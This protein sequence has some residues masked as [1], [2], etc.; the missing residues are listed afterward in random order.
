MRIRNAI[1]MWI[2]WWSILWNTSQAFTWVSLS[3]IMQRNWNEWKLFNQPND[4]IIVKGWNS[5]PFGLNWYWWRLNAKKYDYINNFWLEPL[6]GFQRG[7]K[8]FHVDSWRANPVNP[9]AYH[10]HSYS[11][12]QEG[13]QTGYY[14]TRSS[15]EASKWKYNL[16][17]SK[18]KK[19]GD[20]VPTYYEGTMY[21]SLFHNW[22][23]S[24]YYNVWL[25]NWDV[26]DSFTN[27]LY[28][29]V[30]N[31]TQ[32]IDT[33]SREMALNT[34]FIQDWYYS[35]KLL[36]H[37]SPH[38]YWVTLYVPYAI[39]EH[40]ERTSR[41]NLITHAWHLNWLLNPEE[42]KFQFMFGRS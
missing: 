37:F 24:A 3:W 19:W 30:R 28:N 38:W 20:C 22:S 9:S 40:W 15:W 7:T 33:N 6:G 16:Y 11:W 25:Y 39:N 5:F 2:I 36:W 10:Y 42:A 12:Q 4:V 13:Y 18:G 41:I 35:S 34:N 26:Y 32:N 31:K 14:Y 17:D 8:A 29:D 21:N 23:T 27:A 1:I